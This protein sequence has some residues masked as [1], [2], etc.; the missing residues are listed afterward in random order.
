MG[1]RVMLIEP[2]IDPAT[3]LFFPVA[4]SGLQLALELLII[5]FDLEQVIICKVGPLFFELTFELS[6]PPFELIR[7]H[8][9]GSFLGACV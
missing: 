3:Y 2:I 1:R 4:V 9:S 7:V 5:A 8:T 6:P